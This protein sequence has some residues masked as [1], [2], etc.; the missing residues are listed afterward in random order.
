MAENHEVRLEISS[1]PNIFHRKRVLDYVA[2]E[3]NFTYIVPKK[4]KFLG[5]R[6]Y[7]KRVSNRIN[8]MKLN[9]S[10]TILTI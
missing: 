2:K 1:I 10:L 9:D 3:T 4:Y 7:V 6:K 5:V 8:A